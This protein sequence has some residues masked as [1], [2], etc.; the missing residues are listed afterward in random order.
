M[1]KSSNDSKPSPNRSPE[2]RKRE[3]R[4]A[5]ERDFEAMKDIME[6]SLKHRVF[7]SM[8]LWGF[9]AL[10]LWLF[11]AVLFYLS[12]RS[13]GWT[14][15]QAIYFTFIS[16]LAIGYGDVTL[17]TMSGKAIFVLWSLMVVPTLT[18]LISTACEAVGIPYLKGARKWFK[19]KLFQRGLN[20]VP[21]TERKISSK[22]QA[23]LFLNSTRLTNDIGSHI[24]I[25]ELPHN[26]HDRNY[27][28]IQAI[29]NVIQEHIKTKATDAK[30]EYNFEDWEYIFYLMGVFESNT[31]NSEEKGNIN[32]GG[33]SGD[34][35]EKMID[36]LHGKNPL[37]VSE[38]LTEWMLLELV[39]KL[40]KELDSVRK[41]LGNTHEVTTTYQPLTVPEEDD[42]VIIG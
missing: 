18:M 23:F 1:E 6:R 15:F 7:Y 24:R 19:K 40:E 3:E 27:L 42:K 20:R 38:T 22:L 26:I 25:E 11:G 33:A 8:A 28:L 32:G 13:E 30:V 4:E 39:N 36:W 37:N 41:D 9:F 16:L 35:N 29:K 34:Y 10:F 31:S 14:Y 12:G 2:D 21:T 5:R 17:T